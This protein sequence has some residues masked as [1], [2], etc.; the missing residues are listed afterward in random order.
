MKLKLLLSVVSALLF[1]TSCGNSLEKT[2]QEKLG[3]LT[4]MAELGTVEYTITKIIKASDNS[5]Y[6]IGDRKILF[7]CSAIMKAGIDLKE[8]S[9]ENISINSK[10]K[11]ITILLPKPKVLAF[12]MPPENAK[13]EYEKVGALRFDFT[14]ED[15]N[16]LLRQGEE[17][18]MADAENLGILA[19]AEQNARMFFEALLSQV[20]FE[21]INVVFNK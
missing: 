12:N 16:N 21:K 15:R 1:F 3:T 17:A 19:D 5:F 14:A 8:F 18:I 6:T 13:L 2:A 10:N 20:G 7:S 4:E 11:E 9:A